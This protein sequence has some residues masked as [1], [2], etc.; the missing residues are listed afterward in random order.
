MNFPK[1]RIALNNE[2]QMISWLKSNKHKLPLTMYSLCKEIGWSF[3]ATRGTIFRIAQKIPD[4]LIIRDIIDGETKKFKTK[5]A[6][7]GT[8]S[9]QKLLQDKDSQPNPVAISAGNNI[10]SDK[11]EK[12]IFFLKKML[13]INSKASQ[14]VGE[15]EDP[16][17][18]EKLIT[19]QFGMEKIELDELTKLI[20]EL[21]T[22]I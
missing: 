19:Y 8:P 2:Q 4:F 6:M 10:S 7:K 16:L 20:E 15:I 21:R 13:D 5:V 12:I 18:L 14:L 1:E 9:E 17:I 11:L 3:G 22:K